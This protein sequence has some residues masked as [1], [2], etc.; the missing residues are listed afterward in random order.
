MI[1]AYCTMYMAV[2]GCI[3]LYTAVYSHTQIIQKVDFCIQIIW[4]KRYL[5]EMVLD[6]MKGTLA[7]VGI[8]CH[9]QIQKDFSQLDSVADLSFGQKLDLCI[10]F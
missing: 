4:I 7:A 1:Q 5:D 2:Y 8:Y 9:I 10:S 6:D 3:R